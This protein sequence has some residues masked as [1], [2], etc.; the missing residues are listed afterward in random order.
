MPGDQAN[1]VLFLASDEAASVTGITIRVDGGIMQGFWA[2]PRMAPPTA[3]PA[4]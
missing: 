3:R 2:D 4:S 1:V